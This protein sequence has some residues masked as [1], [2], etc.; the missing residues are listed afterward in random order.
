MTDAVQRAMQKV[1]DA[2]SSGAGR[3]DEMNERLL[4]LLRL[5]WGGAPGVRL[6][7]EVVNLNL[8]RGSRAGLSGFGL[9]TETV[10]PVCVH[11]RLPDTV[12]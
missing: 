5:G 3:H 11:G 2:L 6:A 7:V 1:L 9:D 8:S 12:G 4:E 10:D